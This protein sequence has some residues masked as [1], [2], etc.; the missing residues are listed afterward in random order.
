MDDSNTLVTD[1]EL[2]KDTE[3]NTLLLEEMAPLEELLKMPEEIIVTAD[4][5]EAANYDSEILQETTNNVHEN[6]FYQAMA[7][8]KEKNEYIKCM[9]GERQAFKQ[10]TITYKKVL[11]DMETK[12]QSTEDEIDELKKQLENKN[13][14]LEIK[15]QQLINIAQEKQNL[16]QEIIYLKKK[17]HHHHHD[18]EVSPKRRKISETNQNEIDEL[19]KTVTD[20][21]LQLNQQR[22]CECS[23]QI[24]KHK[25]FIKEMT[26][27]YNTARDCVMHYKKKAEHL[28]VEL[29]N[30]EVF[31]SAMVTKIT[32]LCTCKK[33]PVVSK[34]VSN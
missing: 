23:E 16:Q 4:A 7:E 1:M 2:A 33:T 13:R 22:T 32:K 11:L 9:E 31:W 34:R 10:K 28:Q 25:Q 21:Q 27:N 24:T 19:K 6:E 26:K 15:N 8:V 12:L 29:D 5:I 18:E 14:E 30:S 20:L 3:K 17:T